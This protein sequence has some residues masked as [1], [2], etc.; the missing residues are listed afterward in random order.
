MTL[1]S[2]RRPIKN[3]M[4][5]R[6]G[7]HDAPTI[8]TGT[9]RTHAKINSLFAIQVFV[10]YIRL[11][12][13]RR[14]GRVC[15]REASF[16]VAAAPSTNRRRGVLANRCRATEATS[17]SWADRS[18]Q[19]CFDDRLGRQRPTGRRVEHDRAEF[20][21]PSVTAGRKAGTAI[22]PA[23]TR[24]TRERQNRVRVDSASNTRSPGRI[25]HRLLQ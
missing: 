14:S 2:P 20:A 17:S 7:N 1:A 3:L 25:P 4:C 13:D 9:D 21:T 19:A 16:L 24:R 22:A 12:G 5:G 15:R 11:W 6:F 10:R 18:G 8:E 23:A